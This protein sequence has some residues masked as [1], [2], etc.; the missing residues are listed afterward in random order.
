MEGSKV[1]TSLIWK[2][3]ERISAQ[4]VSFAIS[5]ILARLLMPE[6]YGVISMILVF[7][8]IADVF[9]TSG[10]ASSLIQK[11][12]AN[13][14]DFSTMFFLSFIMSILIYIALFLLAP[15]IANFYNMLDLTL[16]IR[17]FA[18]KL[19]IASVNSIQ[20]AYVSKH[21]IFKK[22]FF[23]TLI[24]T[25]ISGVIGIIMAY[26]GFGVW[27][28]VAQY[29]SNS[30]IDTLVLF[31]TIPWRPKLLF[32]TK[33]AKQMMKFGWKVTVAE[34]ISNIYTEL[35]SLIIGKLYTSED[36][37]YYKKGNQ[38]PELILNNVDT[39]IGSVLFPAI[40]NNSDSKENVKRMTSKAIKIST[41]LIFPM[42]VGMFVVAEPLI[43]LL[44]TEK[45]S[46]AILFMQINC[47]GQMVKPLSTANNQA[48]KALGRSDIFLK[49]EITKKVI[50]VILI[51]SVMS[52]SVEAIAYSMLLYAVISTIINIYP[53]K[54][55]MNYS[56]KEQI[57]DLLPALFVSAIMG[58]VC[59]LFNYLYFSEIITIILQVVSGVIIYLILSK[60]FKLEAYIM[61]KE[62]L[63]KIKIII[64]I[65]QIVNK[66]KIKIFS[67]IF[68][69]NIFKIDNKKI[70]FDN[71]LGRGYGCNPKYIAEEI[72]EEGLDYDLVWL[73]NDINQEMPS[74]IRKVKYGSIKAL[75]ELATA[76]IWVDNVR[77]YKGI[78]KKKN[79]FYIQTWHGSMGLKR[80]EKDVEDT[81]TKEY[82]QE[83]KYDGTIIDLLITNNKFQEEYFGEN[84]WYN[85]EIL[86][87]GNP[88]NDI[89][90]K[91]E[92]RIFEKVYEYFGID[93]NKKIVMYAPTFRKEL[94]MEVY[95]FDYEKCCQVL[96]NKFNEEYVM[97][98]R[99]HP[100]ISQ[101]SI[102]IKY[103]EKVKNASNYPDIQELISV[104]DVIITDYSSLCFDGGLVGKK[105]FTIAK[106]FE[107]YIRNDRRLLYDINDIPFKINT[108]EEE[109][110]ENINEFD[111]E[112]YKQKLQKFYSKIGVVH[113]KNA[114]KE[115]VNIIKKE[116][117]E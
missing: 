69:S 63:K 93:K 29:L 14:K 60:V 105:S 83:A 51:F 110:Y 34:L 85:G 56:L 35:R 91:G 100:N 11:K 17:V 23:S 96:S 72:I 42:M 37:A 109:L 66:I 113:N 25:I 4:F 47:I 43:N 94:N 81:L 53:N 22:F 107:E 58:V 18:L 26:N 1:I 64:K 19:P 67:K 103:N 90:Y 33:S 21:L 87:C 95:K 49:M 89:L 65:Y 12:D 104:V 114:S 82:V 24:G 61:L 77:N 40:S 98:I 80:C 101:E 15:Y 54:K 9:V 44:L 7:I 97:L 8:T 76:K 30:F 10:F 102:G 20:H 39:S 84:F 111:D 86:C 46:A 3:M 55:L 78:H 115:V 52:I 79:Q 68:E 62:Y 31:I 99:L 48:I 116:I 6:D 70:V 73:V 112:E 108:T 27:A 28:L 32:S 5:I 2:F 13:E 50:G 75:Y 88:R 106:D 59:N 71:F 16:I 38:F 74:R 45:W 117:E 41:Y 57:K 36:L 92:H